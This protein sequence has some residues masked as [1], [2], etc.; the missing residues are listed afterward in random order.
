MD[1]T[2]RS[3]DPDNVTLDSSVLWPVF[4]RSQLVATI[5]S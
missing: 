2:T 3:T 4:L 1:Y 5:S